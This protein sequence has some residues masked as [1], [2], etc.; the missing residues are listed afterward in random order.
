MISKRKHFQSQKKFAV[1]ENLA[2]EK[3]T[4]LLFP[5]D[6]SLKHERNVLEPN[7]DKSLCSSS[8]KPNPQR[9]TPRAFPTCF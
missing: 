9:G 3:K 8:S 7:L 4:F 6:I 5:K 1:S 2:V